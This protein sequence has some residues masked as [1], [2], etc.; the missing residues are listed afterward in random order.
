MNDANTMT[1]VPAQV[2]QDLIRNFRMNIA[3]TGPVTRCEEV[4]EQQC[5]EL[6]SHLTPEGYIDPNAGF[7]LEPFTMGD[8]VHYV[9]FG[10]Q[11]QS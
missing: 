10:K 8:N 1:A 4:M 7:T 11:A 6:Q 2:L 9:D 3:M 5:A